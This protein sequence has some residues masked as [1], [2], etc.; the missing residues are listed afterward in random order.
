MTEALNQRFAQPTAQQIQQD[1]KLFEVIDAFG[2]FFFFFFFF[3]AE[4]Q[5]TA[6][7]TP[8]NTPW[9]A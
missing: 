9:W 6:T 5:E 7:G 4:L 8:W 1:L 3:L 2:I